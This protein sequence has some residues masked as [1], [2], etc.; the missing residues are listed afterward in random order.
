[1]K[2]VKWLNNTVSDP[3][4]GFSVAYDRQ[5]GHRCPDPSPPL[6]ESAQASRSSQRGYTFMGFC[7]LDNLTAFRLG[8]PREKGI[9]CAI[10]LFVK[11]DDEGF[12]IRKLG[13]IELDQVDKTVQCTQK[14]RK[15]CKHIKPTGTDKRS[16]SVSVCTTE[17]SGVSKKAK[18]PHAMHADASLPDDDP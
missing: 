4:Y 10:C 18:T 7:A 1:M 8:P 6:T 13:Y 9:R 16:H 3:H 12:H 2:L 15:L 17:A 5:D 11:R 14:L